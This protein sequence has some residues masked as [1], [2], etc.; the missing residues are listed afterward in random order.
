MTIIE[1]MSLL[2]ESVIFDRLVFAFSLSPSQPHTHCKHS[3]EIVGYAL[4]GL[5][6]HTD[7]HIVITDACH[8]NIIFRYSFWIS[9]TVYT[10]THTQRLFLLSSTSVLC[11]VSSSSFWSLLCFVAVDVAAV[12]SRFVFF[13]VHLAWI[14]V[15]FSFSVFRL[16]V[17]LLCYAFI[18][19]DCFR[20]NQQIELRY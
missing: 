2:I 14:F 4:H 11:C 6:K 5:P 7:T 12:F 19:V 8:H 15:C 1:D 13:S 17:V 20:L 10:N 18:S 9:S 16:L 3:N